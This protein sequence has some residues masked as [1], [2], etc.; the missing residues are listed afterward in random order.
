MYWKLNSEISSVPRSR[1]YIYIYIYTHTDTQSN[2][3]VD[4]HVFVCI[5]ENVYLRMYVHKC[6]YID[7]I[8]I[9]P[10]NSLVKTFVIQR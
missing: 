9:S 7:Q 1:I 10:L 8:Y 6:V 2:A 3:D 4:S 5:H